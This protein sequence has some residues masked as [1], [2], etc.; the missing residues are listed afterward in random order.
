MYVVHFGVVAAA[1]AVAVAFMLMFAVALASS[2]VCILREE[3]GGW[4]LIMVRRSRE[5][6]WIRAATAADAAAA[7]AAGGR[8]AGSGVVDVGDAVVTR[9]VKKQ[10]EEVLFIVVCAL[11]G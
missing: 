4:L 1:F 2:C 6:G 7:A 10:Q 5:A 3:L 9:E 8:G 11:A